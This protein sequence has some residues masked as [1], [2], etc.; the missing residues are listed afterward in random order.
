MPVFGACGVTA[1]SAL[2]TAQT[3]LTTARLPFAMPPTS[4]RPDWQA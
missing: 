3:A 1:Q 2:T 4:S